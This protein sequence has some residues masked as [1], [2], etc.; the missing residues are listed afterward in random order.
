MSVSVGARGLQ[1][2]ANS[3]DMSEFT[4]R[5]GA[6]KLLDPF[7]AKRSYRST[8][9]AYPQALGACMLAVE[10]LKE[11]A[12]TGKLGPYDEENGNSNPETGTVSSPMQQLLFSIFQ[13]P[14]F[15][16]GP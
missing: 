6:A 1:A 16:G 2:G 7:D 3:C 9:L 4:Y 14:F 10:Q 15:R 12:K 5:H 11:A 8:Q 13:F